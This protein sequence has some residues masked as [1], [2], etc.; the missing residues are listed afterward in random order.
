MQGLFSDLYAAAARVLK[1]GGRLV[2]VNPL[3]T[4]P[5]DPSLKLEYRKTVDLGGFNCR[6]EMYLKVLPGKQPKQA[7]AKPNARNAKPETPGSKKSPTPA[8]WS[9]VGHGGRRAPRREGA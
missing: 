8:W 1:I 3:R 6:L 7:S 5:T 9:R 4:E 2:F